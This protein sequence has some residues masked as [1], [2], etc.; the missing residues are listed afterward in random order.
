MN[1]RTRVTELPEGC[2]LRIRAAADGAR[3]PSARSPLDMRVNV[4]GAK[5]ND[6]AAALVMLSCLVS[7][8]HAFFD[9]LQ[10]LIG[11]RLNH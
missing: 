9:G 8:A 11:K 6:H 10:T 4:I 7:S 2:M 1:G 5:D 3:P